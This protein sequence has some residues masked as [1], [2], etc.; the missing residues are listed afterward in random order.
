MTKYKFKNMPCR[1]NY[2]DG[3]M[4]IPSDSEKTESNQT[5]KNNEYEA[6]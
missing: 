4:Q 1:N 6:G 5:V 3:T 2:D